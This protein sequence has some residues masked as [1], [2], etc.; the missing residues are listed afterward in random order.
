MLWFRVGCVG[1]RVATQSD[2]G[3]EC[4]I[5][6]VVSQQLSRVYLQKVPGSSWGNEWM[7]ALSAGLIW[8]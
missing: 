8:K 3:F 6:N 5:L 4:D 1:E 2:L 7:D